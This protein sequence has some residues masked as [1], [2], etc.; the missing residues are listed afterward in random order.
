[1]CKITGYLSAMSRLG[2][3]IFADGCDL[4]V[5]RRWAEEALVD[6]FTT[7][8]TLARRAGVDDYR[9]FALEL[10]ELAGER[11]VSVAALADDFETMEAEA[12]EIASWGENVFVKIPFCNTL[13][14]PSWELVRRLAADGVATNVT[15]ILTVER[16]R[17]A[18]QALAEAPA[19]FVSLFA[20]RIADTGRDP[21][22]HVAAAL[23]ALADV[24]RVELIWASPREPLNVR[25]AADVGCHAIAVTAAILDK[26]ELLGKDLDVLALETV[27]SFAEDGRA[28]GL[29]LETASAGAS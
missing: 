14:E 18:A 22:P 8:P 10:L 1:M 20:G 13:G 27:R 26:L 25:Q 3:K 11:P 21:L 15:A 4:V 24:P 29:A 16:V 5:A 6:G 12:R 19:A 7:N 9:T 23:E 2:V 28:A 17:E